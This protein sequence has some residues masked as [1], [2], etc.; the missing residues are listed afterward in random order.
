[1]VPT[2]D[3]YNTSHSY[4][5][6]QYKEMV[7]TA[8]EAVSRIRP[9]HRVFIGSGCGQPK[10]LVD[11]LLARAEKLEDMEVIQ[12]LTLSEPIFRHAELSE[13][14]RLNRFFSAEWADDKLQTRHGEHTPVFLSDIP[15]MIKSGRLPIDVALVQVTP[16]NAQ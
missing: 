12:L 3:N 15:R 6:A 9:E 10:I 11:A 13:H 5:L 2:E 16:P 4:W 14:F 1:M 8:D 7:V